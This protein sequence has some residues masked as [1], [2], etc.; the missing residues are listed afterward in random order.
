MV[1]LTIPAVVVPVSRKNIVS[2]VRTV[3]VDPLELGGINE[4]VERFE[5]RLNLRVRT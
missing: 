1:R 5:V 3:A 2:S 4:G